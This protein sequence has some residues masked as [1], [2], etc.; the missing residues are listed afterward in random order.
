MGELQQLRSENDP[1]FRWTMISNE[2]LKQTNICEWQKIT[3]EFG[4]MRGYNTVEGRGG[5]AHCFAK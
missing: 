4:G 1:L 5:S 2:W 3:A